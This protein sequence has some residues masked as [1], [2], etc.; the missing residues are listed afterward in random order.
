MVLNSTFSIFNSTLINKFSG[1]LGPEWNYLC[2]LLLLIWFCKIWKKL[3]L[4]GCPVGCYFIFD[5]WI[6]FGA[7]SE[8]VDDI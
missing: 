2:L 1:L 7:S 6:I 5:M 4:E 3:R 8:S